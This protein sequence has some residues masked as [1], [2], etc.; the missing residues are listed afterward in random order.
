[1]A[2]PGRES[3]GLPK[4]LVVLSEENL[5]PALDERYRLCRL[6]LSCPHEKEVFVEG[7]RFC[8]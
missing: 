7:V 1:M 8:Q 4:H 5:K 2:A 6:G 3:V